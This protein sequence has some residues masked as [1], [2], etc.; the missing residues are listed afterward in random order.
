MSD[1]I[2]KAIKNP[3]SFTR[4]AK[5]NDMTVPQFTKE[6]LSHKKNY[7]T[8]TIRRAT[9]AKTFSKMRK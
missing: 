3:G 1:W 5:R 7:D 6:V 9:L 4:Q 8:T 2:Q